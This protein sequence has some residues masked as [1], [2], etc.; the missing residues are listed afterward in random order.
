MLLLCLQYTRQGM[1]GKGSI[2]LMYIFVST[3]PM[4]YLQSSYCDIV[5][6]ELSNVAKPL[7]RIRNGAQLGWLETTS[8]DD[9]NLPSRS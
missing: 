5:V 7:P 6:S 3:H 8:R 9:E 2:I 4:F 1:S